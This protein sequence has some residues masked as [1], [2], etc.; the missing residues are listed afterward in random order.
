[1]QVAILH[2]PQCRICSRICSHHRH[3]Q[4]LRRWPQLT[5]NVRG[6]HCGGNGTS[7]YHQSPWLHSQWDRPTSADGCGIATPPHD[8]LLPGSMEQA[9]NGKEVWVLASLQQQIVIWYQDSLQHVGVTQ[10][11]K[12]IGQTFTLKGLCTM[13]E[14]HIT[15]CN[16]CQCNKHSKK[17]QYGKLPLVPVL[18]NKQP[19]E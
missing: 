19:W 3:W 16:S 9:F 15:T 6:V 12:T 17:Q 10:I 8:G 13:V 1:M 11:I 14:E 7:I 4:H 5:F 18:C 2:L